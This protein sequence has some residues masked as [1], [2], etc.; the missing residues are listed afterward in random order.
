M[1]HESAGQGTQTQVCVPRNTYLS[2]RTEAAPGSQAALLSEKLRE[3]T[4]GAT[5]GHTGSDESWVALPSCL[6]LRTEWNEPLLHPHTGWSLGPED[7]WEGDKAR[8]ETL[9]G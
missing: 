9:F 1:T 7:P 8:D 6:D 5:M 4:E 2:V 3:L